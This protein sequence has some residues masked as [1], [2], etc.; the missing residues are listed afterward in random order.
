MSQIKVYDSGSNTWIPAIVGAPGPTGATGASGYV[1]SDGSTGPTGPQ[2]ATGVAGVN[3]ATG[4]TGPAGT[5]GATGL[6]GPTGATG[7]NGTN[8]ATGLT[9]PTGATGLTGATGVAGATGTFSGT[10]TA[11]LD[12]NGFSISNVANFSANTLVGTSSNVTL[13]AGS[14]SW[15]FDNTGNLTTANGVQKIVGTANTGI[16]AAYVGVT[17][18]ILPNTIV[19]FTSNVNYYTQVTLQNKSTGADATADYILTADNGSDTVNYLDLGIINSG[20]DANTPT[21]SLGNIVYATVALSIWITI[22]SI[23]NIA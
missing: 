18:T 3:G 22:S 10:L 8:G 15:T 1:G 11:N 4:S 6:T 14:Y 17:N 13:T 23:D 12:G 21:N 9:G 7:A 19:S 5:N 16:N 20:Y 2:G